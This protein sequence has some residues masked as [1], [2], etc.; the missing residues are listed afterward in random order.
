MA[1]FRP[2]PLAPPAPPDP[3][4]ASAADADAAAAS[5]AATPA[6]FFPLLPFP[7]LTAL[8]VGDSPPPALPLLPLLAAEAASL[9]PLPWAAGPPP[10]PPPL[11]P[12]VILSSSSS[13]SLMPPPPP[14]N[15]VPFPLLPGF[16]CVVLCHVL[17]E[18][19]EPAA[20]AVRDERVRQVRAGRGGG[21]IHRFAPL[22]GRR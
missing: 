12:P 17:F 16:A 22:A 2:F 8:P 3:A 4:D 5:A 14:P 6:D 7:L 1:R 19:Q 9:L 13:P 21:R 11:V 10:P 15:T 18:T 20:G